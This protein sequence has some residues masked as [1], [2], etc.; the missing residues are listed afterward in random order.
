MG[1]KD[2]SVGNVLVIVDYFGV[3]TVDQRVDDKQ[4]NH[5]QQKNE[6]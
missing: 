5:R 3:A 4:Q 2:L 6:T 1:G